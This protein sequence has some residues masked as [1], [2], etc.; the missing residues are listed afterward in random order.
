MLANCLSI[1]SS[2]E[3]ELL[4]A[5]L[6]KWLDLYGRRCALSALATSGRACC[7][8]VLKRAMSKREIVVWAEPRDSAERAAAAKAISH[9]LIELA[10]SLNMHEELRPFVHS[11]EVSLSHA[12]GGQHLGT[13]VNALCVGIL[14]GL[15]EAVLRQA[16][17]CLDGVGRAR[18][19]EALAREIPEM[20]LISRRPD[21]V[22]LRRIHI[23]LLAGADPDE[24]LCARCLRLLRCMK[25]WDLRR[26]HGRA[27]LASFLERASEADGHVLVDLFQKVVGSAADEDEWARIFRRLSQRGLT[28]AVRLTRAAPRRE[29]HRCTK[30]LASTIAVAIGFGLA[31]SEIKRASALCDPLVLYRSLGEHLAS[32]CRVERSDGFLAGAALLMQRWLAYGADLTC[33]VFY[34]AGD[35]DAS[36]NALDIVAV[37]ARPGFARVSRELAD[38]GARISA[39]AVLRLTKLRP[40]D[41][42]ERSAWCSMWRRLASEQLERALAWG[43][44]GPPPGVLEWCSEEWRQATHRRRRFS[45]QSWHAWLAEASRA[46]Y[47]YDVSS[48][49]NDPWMG[50]L[51]PP[52]LA[53]VAAGC[54]GSVI[55]AA[56]RALSDQAWEQLNSMT[57]ESRRQSQF[58]TDVERLEVARVLAHASATPTGEDFRVDLDARYVFDDSAS[59]LEQCGLTWVPVEY[60][61]FGQ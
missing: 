61:P 55:S 49:L 26:P 28:D 35:A 47:A 43:E 24:S 53:A 7:T 8:L 17:D 44:E 56:R 59:L 3:P 32:S 52:F 60:A 20:V 33:E 22:T 16:K 51:I 57:D 50:S 39:R 58:S 38:R 30:E 6:L 42:T 11:A 46:V 9:N 10:L 45:L 13:D 54:R 1:I 15:P 40:D 25:S 21:S 19:D 14:L 37:D 48:P 29:D 41:G 34:A 12:E 27:V 4:R 2:V 36:Y 5:T 18:L 23:L 31:S